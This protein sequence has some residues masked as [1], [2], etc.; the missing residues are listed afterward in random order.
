MNRNKFADTNL[1]MKDQRRIWVEA[2]QIWISKDTKRAPIYIEED[3]GSD[4]FGVYILG[5]IQDQMLDEERQIKSN[6]FVGIEIR[7]DLSPVRSASLDRW[8]RLSQMQKSGKTFYLSPV[9]ANIFSK[10]DILRLYTLTEHRK[11][12]ITWDRI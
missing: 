9:D 11:D 4:M 8:T 2:G 1:S 5:Y 6:R 10:Q 12:D 3:R 7:Q